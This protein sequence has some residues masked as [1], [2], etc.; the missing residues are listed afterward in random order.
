MNKRKLEGPAAALLARLDD[1]RDDIERRIEDLRD[2][3]EHHFETRQT[4]LEGVEAAA[5]ELRKRLAEYTG[6]ER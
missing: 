2:D 3:I 1:L 6:D 5:A 4:E